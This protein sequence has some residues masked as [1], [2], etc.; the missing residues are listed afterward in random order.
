MTRAPLRLVSE[1][2]A[3]EMLGF[4]RE[5]FG[6]PDALFARHRL[7]RLSKKTLALASVAAAEYALA[8]DGHLAGLPFLRT[9]RSVPKLTTAAAQRFGAAMTANTVALEGE[10][11]RAFVRGETVP[12]DAIPPGCAHGD[13]V[14][15]RALGER[16]LGVGV[17]FLRVP[18]ETGAPVLLESRF[19]KAWAGIL[20]KDR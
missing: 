2:E 7:I 13:V 14:V 16:W 3:A 10:R 4:V 20:A 5:R 8:T 11:L 17:A 19:P 6:L 1:A 15:R 12:F 9:N 18:K